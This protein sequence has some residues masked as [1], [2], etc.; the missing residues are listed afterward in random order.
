MSTP[1]S[2]PAMIGFT[3]IFFSMVRRMDLAMSV[4]C[5]ASESLGRDRGTYVSMIATWTVKSL[6][7]ICRSGAGL[8]VARDLLQCD[9][10]KSRIGAS[11]G[12]GS[13]ERC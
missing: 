2:T 10:L 1:T 4:N 12:V 11:K 13:V 9:M 5:W 3:K 7:G 6:A 8:G